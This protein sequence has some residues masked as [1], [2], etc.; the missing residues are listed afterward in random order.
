MF[1]DE[2]IYVFHRIPGVEDVTDA[3]EAFSRLLH[4][5]VVPFVYVG[6]AIL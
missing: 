4:F 5:I 1:K 3:S 6:N 2:L